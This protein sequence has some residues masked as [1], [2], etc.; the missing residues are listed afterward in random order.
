VSNYVVQINMKDGSKRFLSLKTYK[1]TLVKTIAAASKFFRD[2]EAEFVSSHF[3][4][5]YWDHET[6]ET[7]EIAWKRKKSRT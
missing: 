7:R 2:T 3:N 1:P 4:Q 6:M 5:N